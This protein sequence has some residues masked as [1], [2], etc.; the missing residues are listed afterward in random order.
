MSRHKDCAKEMG[1]L[2]LAGLWLESR[3]S[4]LTIRR[5]MGQTHLPFVA[6]ALSSFAAITVATSDSLLSLLS[7]AASA[8]TIIAASSIAAFSF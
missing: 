4:M 7:S 1:L 2:P 5:G 6:G 8:A 3:F